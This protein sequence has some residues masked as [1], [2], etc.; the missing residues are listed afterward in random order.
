MSR[1]TLT[2]I[3]TMSKSALC[4][5]T[6][7]MLS[8]GPLHAVNI[9]E[10]DAFLENTVSNNRVP[11]LAVAL[12]QDDRIAFLKGY[13]RGVT[14]QTPFYIGSISKA[15][16]ATAVMQL[17]ERRKLE[18][19]APVQRY[20]P[21]FRVADDAASRTVTL[22][23]LLN[24]T[25]GMSGD[26]RLSPSLQEQVRR[27]GEVAF[28]APVG[29]RFQYANQN[30]RVLAVLIE[31]V[32][33]CSY[34]EY[35]RE[36]V[37]GPL[38]MRNSLA[39]SGPPPGLAQAHGQLF[40]GPFPRRERFEP[41]SQ[42]SGYISSTAEEMA[43][44][45]IAMLNQG[46]YRGQRVLAPEAVAEMMIPPPGIGSEYGFGWMISTVGAV[47]GSARKDR[48]VYHGG[49]LPTYHAF[50]FMLPGKRLG[51]VYLCNQNGV[52]PM[53]TWAQKLKTA[54]IGML[55]ADP[56]P[57][58]PNF[59]WMGSLLGVATLFTLALQLRAI[60]RLRR[61]RLKVARKSRLTRWLRSLPD[62][63]IPVALLLGV[64]WQYPWRL[65]PDV[66]LWVWAACT[67]SIVRGLM[68][69]ALVL[70]LE[71]GT[72]TVAIGV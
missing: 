7:L 2:A 65:L 56:A 39:G 42:S 67:L 27:T 32:S 1:I 16:T 61:W 63:L 40:G 26:T 72:K 5:F 13:P 33:G 45:L 68:K 23:N 55:L 54:T 44:L 48:I 18:L 8:A 47:T 6:L 37:F 31:R 69:L 46:R 3:L 24:H 60:G 71:K 10:L 35:V 36:H 21:G 11:G 59:G 41:A 4:G 50:A 58:S 62:L 52:L 43:H 70:G 49:A 17:V 38:E 57:P 19:D 66:T 14:P 53:V 29:A 30:Y 34:G 15:I 20:L 64:G 25:S 22:R 51:F 28:T 12:V 9:R